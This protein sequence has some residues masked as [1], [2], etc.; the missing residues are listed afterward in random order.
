MLERLADVLFVRR[1]RVLVLSLLGLVIAAVI[2]GP[3]TGLLSNGGFDDPKSESSRATAYLRDRMGTGNPDV[4]VLVTAKNGQG[5][6]D[7]PAV[8]DAGRRYT[9]RL[10]ADPRLRDV[11]SYWSA[12][13]VPPLRSADGQSALVVAQVRGP[14][15]EL[16]DRTKEVA[17]LLRDVSPPAD[18]PIDVRLSGPGPVFSEVN[19][20]IEHDLLRAE[21]I[22][23]PVTA[24]L[25]IVV[26]GSA[27]AAMLPLA[28]GILSIVG[29][30]LVLRLLNGVTDVSVFALN[31]TT[32]MGLGL[33][34]DYSLFLVSRHREELAG[35]A[36]PQAALRTTLRTAGRTVLFSA[37][38]VGAAVIALLVF[39]L[40]FLRSF[41]YAG[42]AVVGFAA[43]AAVVVLPAL[44]AIAGPRINAFDLRKPVR[45]LLRLGPVP[46][47]GTSSGTWHRI[48]TTVMRRPWPIATAVIALLVVLG[49]PFLH[50]QF[51]QSDDRV[52]PTSAESRSVGDVLRTQFTIGETQS[53]DVVAPGLRDDP[54][55]VAALGTHAQALS[56]IPGVARVETAAGVYAYGKPIATGLPALQR[57]A[58]PQGS[59]ARVVPTVEGYSTA[60]EDLAHAVRA[61]PAPFQT[62][63]AGQSAEFVDVKGS[64]GGRLPLALALMGLITLV[65]LFLF[66]GSVVLPIKAVVLNLLSL[67]A[68]FGALVWIFQEGHGA[69]LLDFAPT[70]RLDITMRVLM[71][72]LG[73]G[74]SRGWGVFLLS[75][76]REEYLRTGDNRTA[77]AMGLERTGRLITA[78][79]GL[80]AIVFLSFAS[81][82]VTF[83]KMMGIG[84]A[85]AVIVDATL[86]RAALVPAFM[87]IT[88]RFNWWA[89]GPLRRLHARIGLRE[90]VAVAPYGAQPEEEDADEST[91]ST[92]RARVQV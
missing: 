50:A 70:G 29:T 91:G 42:A 7:D 47:P 36:E 71:F 74:R 12:G 11:T 5:K 17:P 81:S 34:I 67:S 6:V 41:A 21:M 88:G 43:L 83:I 80:L 3:V 32:S 40:Y 58:T 22:A 51:G 66:T 13:S 77:V 61:V 24:V 8:A 82:Q 19:T 46:T 87:R 28:I 60:G 89:P 33:G 52:L 68:T 30:L 65:V 53:L 84:L 10:A 59:W 1:R 54:A 20:T 44:L 25:L 64:I 79:A 23:I 45:R 4:V 49:T 63:V 26:F 73:L 55:D 35:G 14:A 31:L 9:E 75:R 56:A 72:A 92:E 39:P 86:V 2:G 85:L 37:V 69:G 62:M 76:I 90:D 57:Y 27:I 16:V 15:D 18:G 38:T 78:A 48:A